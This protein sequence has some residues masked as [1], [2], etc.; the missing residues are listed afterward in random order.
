MRIAIRY[1]RGNVLVVTLAVSIVLGTILASYL[2]LVNEQNMLSYR[3]QYWNLAIGVAEAGIEEALTQIHFTNDFTANGWAFTN[4]SFIKTRELPGPDFTNR[5]SVAIRGISSPTLISTGYVRLPNGEEIKRIV[6]V[7]TRLD[8]LFAK[9]MVAKGTIDMNGN[10]VK[11]DSF[12]SQDPRFS[13]NGRYDPTRAKDNGDV[14]TNLQIVNGVDIGNANIWGHVSTGPGGTVSIGANGAVGNA[15]WQLSGQKGIQP[16]FSSDDMNVNFPDVTVPFTGGAFTPARKLV[17]GAWY[18][19][20]IDSS[21]NWQLASLD[22][23][24]VVTSNSIAKLLITEEISLTGQNA[25]IIQP[26]GALQLYMQ[27]PYAKIGG[28]GVINKSGNSTNF[29]Y[30]GLSSNTTLDF[31]GNGEFIGVIYAPYAAFKLGGGGSSIQDFIGA[32]ITASVTMQGHFN[33]HYDENLSRSGKPR[34][35]IITSWNEM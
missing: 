30:Y 22:K 5:Y 7:T 33:F 1:N 8:A 15:L 35:F 20:V 29:F 6:R 32:S 12:D 19:Y 21:G 28:N 14:A 18:D 17:D 31:N 16:G 34:G 2:K 4:L 26:G 27:G 3:S 10:N 24:L 13:V 11:S 9:G 25:I 23:T